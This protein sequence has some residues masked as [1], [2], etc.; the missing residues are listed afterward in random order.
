MADL[1]D[2]L[3]ADV[4][5]GAQESWVS[6][7]T[8]LAAES[9]ARACENPDEFRLLSRVSPLGAMRLW[10][11]WE[12]RVTS[13]VESAWREA[14]AEEDDEVVSTLTRRLGGRSYETGYAANVAASAA[15][16][17]AEVMRRE[18]V[19][20]AASAEREWYAATAEAVLRVEG[21]DSPRRA[22]GDA[23]SRL[24]RLGMTTID[25][26][27]GVST[28]V[29]AALRRHLVTQANQARNDVLWRRMDEWGCD[30]V[31]TTAHYG[32][33]PTHAVWQGRVFSRSGRSAKYP[34]LVEATGYGT[35]AGLCGVNCRHR[36]VP[37]V[38][39]ASKLP[40]TDYS[41][42]ERLTGMTSDEY[43][44]ATQVQRRMEARVR[45]A[46][47]EVAIGQAA[48][49][50]VTA[51]RVRLGE[52]QGRLRDHCRANHLRRDYE[53]ERA[54][55]LPGGMSQPRALRSLPLEQRERL[56]PREQEARGTA[57][58]VSRRAVNGR[59]YRGKFDAAGLPKRA[60]ASCY[61]EA[62]RILRD[63]D[64]T[65]GERM[66]VVSWRTGERACDTFGLGTQAE[67]VGLTLGQYRRA[68]STDG[69]VVVL[70]NHP[71]STRPSWADLKSVAAHDFVRASLV[72]CHDGT[73][74]VISG[75]SSQL[76][77]A[78]HGI[79]SECRAKY[80][81]SFPEESIEMKAL[82][83]LYGR[84]EVE[85][86]LRIRRL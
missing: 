42:Q 68:A 15:R 31:Y 66:S 36:M 26:K 34:A 49:A 12:G 80:A 70:H 13:G 63:R 45:E 57:Y 5:N 22:I 73:V 8:R 29:D 14:M 27:S 85:R 21:G 4:V 84:N 51:A 77:K 44:A 28:P 11:E 35:A 62:R 6:A 43:Y 7:L 33:R 9:L 81:G 30:L 72:L 10:A 47:R 40:D 19:A 61:V 24:S 79:L 39:G 37:Y 86:W 56:I 25:Y 67:R 65:D 2:R 3:A 75:T 60:A 71:A 53:R 59:A 17:M 38:E 78:Y 32:A 1:Y 69:G 58:D 50:D 16:G 54:Y 23:V 64:G 46:K 55:G 76:I 48:G 83:E 41:E 20:L 18:N 82:D 52:L 74:Y